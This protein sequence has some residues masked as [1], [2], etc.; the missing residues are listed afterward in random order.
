MEV[1]EAGAIKLAQ[2]HSM[3]VYG[4]TNFVTDGSR[5]ARISGGSPVMPRITAMGCSLT[6]LMG[7][8]A[9]V[10]PP[11]E[12]TTALELLQKLALWR[13]RSKGPGSFQPLF[14][15]ALYNITPTMLAQSERVALDPAKLSLYLITDPRCARTLV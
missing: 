2:I 12:C 1:A 6:C 3:V 10:A 13:Y 9:A 8:F 4:E 11:M 5:T 15:D 14:L 7:G